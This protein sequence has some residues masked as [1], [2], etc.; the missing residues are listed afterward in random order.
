MAPRRGLDGEGVVRANRGGLDDV[1]A[2]A[3]DVPKAVDYAARFLS[4]FLEDKIVPEAILESLEQ[5]AGAGLSATPPLLHAR[6]VVVERG[7][8]RRVRAGG[9]CQ[10]AAPLPTADVRRLTARTGR[11]GGA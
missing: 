1:R 8:W 7:A 3:I 4:H 10:R 6:R 9:M 5:L 2:A 11:L